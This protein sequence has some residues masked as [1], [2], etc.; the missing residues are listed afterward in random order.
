MDN[1]QEYTLKTCDREPT[2]LYIET[3]SQYIEPTLKGLV[4]R[5]YTL[6]IHHSTYLY[7]RELERFSVSVKRV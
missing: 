6:S 7:L 2:L 3:T 1:W 5:H 4:L